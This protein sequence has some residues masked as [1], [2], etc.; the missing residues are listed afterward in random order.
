MHKFT[1]ALLATAIAIPALAAAPA[2]AQPMRHDDHRGM[3]SRQ[4]TWKNFRKGERF[5]RKHARNYQRVDYRKYRGVKAPPRGYEYVRS[6]NDLLLVRSSNG[7]ITSVR[8]GL[9]R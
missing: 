2:I 9:F 1:A 7:M 3:E 5:D 8:S 4:Q 6:G